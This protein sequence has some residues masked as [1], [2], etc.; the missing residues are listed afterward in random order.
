MSNV[1]KRAIA[2]SFERLAS[3]KDISE[4]TVVE[5]A[6]ECGIL[7]QTFYRHF[8]DKY[9]LIKWIY[10]EEII[11]K[12]NQ[13]DK[14]WEENYLEIFHYFLNHKSMVLNIYNSSNQH[15]ILHFIFKQSKPLVMKVVEE[16]TKGVTLSE[17]DFDFLTSFYTGCLG[18]V[19]IHW[20]ELGMPDVAN[21]IVMKTSKV[22]SGNIQHYLYTL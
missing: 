1:T 17:F 11:D 18:A 19:L 4:I 2:Q 12:V 10:A 20:I 8:K 15:Y 21:Q 16:K 22:L 14:S 3:T 9:D 5:I 7:R 6:R 13:S